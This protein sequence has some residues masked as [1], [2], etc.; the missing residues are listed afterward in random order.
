MEMRSTAKRMDKSWMKKKRFSTP[1]IEG[2][3]SFMLFVEENMGRDVDIHCPCKHCL[4][5]F[6]EPQ[7]VVLAHLMINGIDRRYTTWIHHV[8]RHHM[9]RENARL[10]EVNNKLF[11]DNIRQHERLDQLEKA[12]NES[13]ER[14]D[15]SD[16]RLA[17]FDKFVDHLAE[18]GIIDLEKL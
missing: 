8:K 13:K 1:Y 6:K 7:E 18:K 10:I 9:N 14:Q 17:K 5:A 16:Q 2:V 4:N 3:R 15:I 12:L 11:E